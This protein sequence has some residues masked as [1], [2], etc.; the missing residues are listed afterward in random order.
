[1]SSCRAQRL[2]SLGLL[3]GGARVLV[4]KVQQQQQQGQPAIWLATELTKLLVDPDAAAAAGEECTQQQ[5]DFWQQT[6][7]MWEE[8]ERQQQQQQMRRQQHQ[9]RQPPGPAARRQAAAQ[10]VPQ[11][12]LPHPPPA[13]ATVLRV[14]LAGALCKQ[15]GSNR[16]DCQ[17][18]VNGSH[19]H[20]QQQPAPH[21]AL[22]C[23]AAP[24][25]C[26]HVP[27]RTL[28]TLCVWSAL[29]HTG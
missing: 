4:R 10:A 3:Q 24:V 1:M 16:L 2:Q 22:M 6:W 13:A 19:H 21:P 7:A 20:R 8:Q 17:P 14:S 5:R 28:L 23:Q 27:N 18:P 26:M 11:Q 12:Q 9:G 29:L 25:V 15:Q